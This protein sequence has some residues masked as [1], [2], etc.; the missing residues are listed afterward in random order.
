[1][2]LPPFRGHQNSSFGF[3]TAAKSMPASQSEHCHTLRLGASRK[4]LST[5]FPSVA[6]N[7]DTPKKKKINPSS[8]RRKSP[9]V[10][11]EMA[12]MIHRLRAVGMLQHDIAA[13]YSVNQGRISEVLKGRRFP[14]LLNQGSLF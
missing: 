5:G 11:R 6:D 10:T 3:P 12:V 1:M 14:D 2:I 9:R 4:L 7:S 13:L 8:C